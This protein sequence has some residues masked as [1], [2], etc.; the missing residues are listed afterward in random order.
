MRHT[1]VSSIASFLVLHAATA[2][3]GGPTLTKASR[4]DTSQSLAVMAAGAR[5]PAS[6]R[7]REGIEPRVTGPSLSSG[8]AD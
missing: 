6:A 4:H 7:D 5:S 8:R 3:A 2:L 1:L